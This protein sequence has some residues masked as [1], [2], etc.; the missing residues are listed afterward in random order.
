MAG[1]DYVLQGRRQRRRVFFPFSSFGNLLT[2][3]GQYA[4][5]LQQEVADIKAL[6]RTADPKLDIPFIVAVGSKRHHV[7]FFPE[8][9]DQNGNALPLSGPKFTFSDEAACHMAVLQEAC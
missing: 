1:E 3:A 5:V 4:H 7:R 9:G 8:K 6:I 2:F